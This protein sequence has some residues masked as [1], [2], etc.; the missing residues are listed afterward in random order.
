MSANLKAVLGQYASWYAT[1]LGTIQP[2][3]YVFPLSNRLA[4]KD[5]LRPVTSLKTAWESVRD[6]AKVK[7]RLHDL[8]HSFCTKLAEAGVPE[9][10]MLDIMGHVSTAMRRRYSHIRAQA[11]RD[12]IDSVELRQ[13]SVGVTKESTKVGDSAKSKTAVTH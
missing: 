5:P 10:T 6:T 8:R 1:K 11:R 7:C 9:G 12:A 13:F 3:W 2:D 4:L